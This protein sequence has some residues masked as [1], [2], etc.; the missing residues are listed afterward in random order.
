MTSAGN[1]S[2]CYPVGVGL[3]QADRAQLVQQVARAGVGRRGGTAEVVHDAPYR[4]KGSG[5]GAF[6]PPGGEGDVVARQEDAPL[7]LK[8]IVLL[9]VGEEALLVAVVPGQI[10]LEGSHK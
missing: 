10:G 3:V 6:C 7:R 5:D 9:E 8:Q 1:G 2:N 4:I